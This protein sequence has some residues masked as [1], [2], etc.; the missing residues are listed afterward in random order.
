MIRNHKFVSRLRCYRCKTRESSLR[1]WSW[2]R[3]SLGGWNILVNV[4]APTPIRSPG[5]K[6]SPPHTSSDI[7]CQAALFYGSSSMSFGV[8]FE[9]RFK[10]HFF[11]ISIS[12]IYS[13][14][15]LEDL[16]DTFSIDLLDTFVKKQLNIWLFGSI[17]RLYSV[18]LTYLSMLMWITT[19][20]DYI[21]LVNI[22]KLRFT[23]FSIHSSKIA[24]T[25]FAI[26]G[27]SYFHINFRMFANFYNSSWYFDSNWIESNLQ[28]RKNLYLHNIEFSNLRTWYIFL[29]IY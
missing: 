28:F 9:V 2:V 14:I 7:L 21:T 1:A 10:V 17:S 18:P 8:W 19:C 29:P 16:L 24:K 15:F 6:Y 23:S 11:P 5:G 22:P 3:I 13:I 12:S 20:L 26:L 4:Q 25:I 27:P